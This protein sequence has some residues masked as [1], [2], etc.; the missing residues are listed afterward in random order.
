MLA[1]DAALALHLPVTLWHC[2]VALL[3]ASGHPLPGPGDAI[4]VAWLGR[5]FL[6]G[7]RMRQA[8]E[9]HSRRTTTAVGAGWW[10][11]LI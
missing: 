7:R 5:S 4:N 9:Q 10:S 2:L 1:L 3:P 11:V 8:F 6:W